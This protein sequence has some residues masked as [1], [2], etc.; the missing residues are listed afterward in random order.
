MAETERKARDV[1]VLWERYR[2][3]RAYLASSG[4]E[5]TVT[6]CVSFYQGDQWPR[7][8]KATAGLPR[9]VVNICKMIARAKCASVL[10]TPVNIVYSSYSGAD[11][12]GMN[13]FSRYIL[14][15]MGWNRLRRQAFMGGCVKGTYIYH[16]YWDAEGIS[17][18]GLKEGA[19]RCELIDPL[20]VIFANPSEPDEQKQRWIII[21]SRETVESVRAKADPGVD[22]EDI[23]P[24][25]GE[26]PYANEEQKGTAMV[27]VLTQYSRMGGE[28]VCE[29][30]TRT[31]VV[32]A[33]FKLTP[34]VG[35]A[36]REVKRE[37]ADAEETTG[38]DP[39]EN[40]TPD[41]AGS[42]KAPLIGAD[43]RMRLY[44]LVVGRY[45]A[46]E[47]SIYGLGEVEGVIPNQRIINFLLAMIV[48]NVQQNAWG[49]YIV[50]PNALKGQVITN[51]PGQ[52]LTDY[53]QTGNGIK[54]L[55][56]NTISGQ[57]SAVVDAIL[58]MTRVVTG[59]TEVMT[60]ETLGASMSGAAI[61][62]LQSQ[63]QTPI[64]DLRTDEWE[65]EERV[66][67][68]L[69]E[70][71]IN[72]YAGAS[73]VAYRQPT[74]E[75]ALLAKETGADGQPMLRLERDGTVGEE[76]TFRSDEYRGINIDVS[77]EACAGTNASAAGDIQLLSDLL[78]K[79]AIDAKT[80]VR[81]YPD[82]AIS[83]KRA[84]M[85]AMEA[86]DAE[87][88]TV[89][90]AQLEQM[91][92]QMQQ[93]AQKMQE[94]AAALDAVTSTIRKVQELEKMLA[95]LYDE[96]GKKITMQNDMI[97]NGNVALA[98]TVSDARGMAQELYDNVPGV[99]Q[100]VEEMRKA[101]SKK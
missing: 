63:A 19:L 84:M 86:A 34:D 60:G 89:L 12:R 98:Q 73:Y 100:G 53:S 41:D 95:M 57:P 67:R 69:V 66:G 81:M 82:D 90:R 77:V 14:R 68:V 99:A 59:S 35:E 31:C 56:E 28:V 18:D 7:P 27:T 11:M 91:T 25:E 44:P 70:F 54:H 13:D 74:R 23:V 2:N 43:S 36:M 96:A 80:F 9:P 6:R 30:A 93:M 38:E 17:P 92:A 29:K 22:P 42:R 4:M 79:G 3:G 24:D 1:T 76:K 15:T 97:R 16:F 55:P 10:A 62:Q 8:T 83:D 85:D 47:G 94:D 39:S 20:R 45:E 46:R 75:E 37:Q 33:P 58:S 40:G 50:M 72:Y 64:K 78:A 71:F 88:I 48:F 65:V 101:R 52:V 61:A 49:K 87:E 51:E 21:V 26:D 5:R 32:N